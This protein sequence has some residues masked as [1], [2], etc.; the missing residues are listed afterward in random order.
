M[1][2]IKLSLSGSLLFVF[3]ILFAQNIT[4]KTT[5]KVQQWNAT[6][7]TNYS[8]YIRRG[9]ICFSAKYGKSIS[10][11]TSVQYDKLAKDD[12]APPVGSANDGS[13]KLWDC[14][15]SWRPLENANAFVL[16][17][18]YLL[19][20]LSRET[21]TRPWY[22]SS[23]DK[24]QASNLLRKFVTNK[25]NGIS[26]G[27]NLGGILGNNKF[28]I[29]YNA[30]LLE[31]YNHN[32]TEK[33]MLM[34]GRLNFGRG[35]KPLYTYKLTG[36][37]FLEETKVVFGVNGSMQGKTEHFDR[38]LS[39][40]GDFLWKYRY[41]SLTAEAMYLLRT[42]NGVN[43]SGNAAFIRTAINIPCSKG[44]IFEPAL[45]LNT[46]TFDQNE[47]DFNSGS[48]QYLDAGMN[49]YC[50]K[51]AFKLAIHFI[52]NSEPNKGAVSIFNFTNTTC[53]LGLQLIL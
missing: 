8:N 4:T 13:I 31:A 37:T 35:T 21:I 1:S 48:N 49:Y 53:V 2:A 6:D 29:S 9:R 33:A 47:T 23:L 43:Y 11:S 16:T 3:P 7:G 32:S 34:A 19:P 44:R 14:F 36:N 38:N 5:L 10:L 18:G 30:S 52:T 45:L 24:A 41:V 26:P 40:G 42:F 46:F 28:W 51:N 12:W 15:I 50:F 25:T 20:Q 17:T 22:V 39:Y 27:I